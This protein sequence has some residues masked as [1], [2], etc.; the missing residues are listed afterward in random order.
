M[1][2]DDVAAP[3]YRG[4]AILPEEAVAQRFVEIVSE[5]QGWSQTKA[6]NFV[7]DHAPYALP[8]RRRAFSPPRP[9]E[10]R[11]SHPG[12]RQG[13]RRSVPIRS[14]QDPGDPDLP[15]DDDAAHESAEEALA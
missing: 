11:R 4:G 6:L 1:H 7:K 5:Q 2:S 10:R 15:P 12:R 3:R 13:S 9:R 14:G 8:R